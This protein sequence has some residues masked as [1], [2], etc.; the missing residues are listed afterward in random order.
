MATRKAT[1]RRKVS[2]KPS[3]V[4]DEDIQVGMIE[5]PDSKGIRISLLQS[6]R[7]KY[8]AINRVYQSKTDGTWKTRNGLWLP[9]KGAYNIAGI[10][11]LAY[12]EGLKRNWDK[13]EEPAKPAP[14]NQEQIAKKRQDIQEAITETQAALEHL[15]RCLGED[16]GNNIDE[17]LSLFE[18]MKQSL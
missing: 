9:F 18:K 6:G 5:L 17:Q 2:A 3:I 8:I 15:K 7:K 12:I 4:I 10:M 14:E 13:D 1:T 16:K 11:K